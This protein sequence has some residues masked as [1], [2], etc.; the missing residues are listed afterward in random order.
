M[1]FPIDGPFLGAWALIEWWWQGWAIA[2][3]ALSVGSHT[4]ATG[5]DEMLPVQR[6]AQAIRGEQGGCKSLYRQGLHDSLLAWNG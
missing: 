2:K 6:L 1:V 3:T 5:I 4:A